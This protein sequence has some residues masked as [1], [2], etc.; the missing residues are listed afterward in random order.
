MRSNTLNDIQ[1]V[2]IPEDVCDKLLQIVRKNCHKFIR[3]NQEEEPPLRCLDH[4]IDGE[5]LCLGPDQP[6]PYPYL[7]RKDEKLYHGFR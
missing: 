1:T 5:F 2:Q 3:V 4:G 6:H 7:L